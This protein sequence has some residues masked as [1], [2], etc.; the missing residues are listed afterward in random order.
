[1]ITLTEITTREGITYWTIS[2]IV[3]YIGVSK[4]SFT[5]YVAKGFAPTPVAAVERTRLWDAQE[6][7]D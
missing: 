6:I 4:S 1:M 3:E 2:K 5:S 7:K